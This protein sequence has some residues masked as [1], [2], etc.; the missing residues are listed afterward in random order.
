MP[1]E[2]SDADRQRLTDAY[3]EV[4]TNEL[5]PKY[6]MLQDFLKNEYLPVCL[7]TSG[8]GTL[9]NGP[10]TYNYLIRLHTTT[11]MTVDEIHEL[12]KREVARILKEMEKAKN[13]MGFEGGY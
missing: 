9:P 7:E 11:N 10:E 13:N 12:G 2:I 1:Q 6:T 8:I 5:V 4:I 3:T